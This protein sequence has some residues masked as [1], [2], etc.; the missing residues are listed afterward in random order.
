MTYNAFATIFI[1][2]AKGFDMATDDIMK[3]LTEPSVDLNVTARVLGIGI[4][5]ARSAREVGDIPSFRVGKKWRVPTA[6]LREM[7]RLPP[8]PPSGSMPDAA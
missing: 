8:Y 2:M 4:S 1:H 5:A 6:P 3:V 7:L